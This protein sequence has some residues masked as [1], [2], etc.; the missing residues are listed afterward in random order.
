MEIQT[1]SASDLRD[2]EI[3][4][5]IAAKMKEFHDLNMPGPKTVLLWDRLRYMLL[6]IFSF[7]CFISY[8]YVH[9]K[10]RSQL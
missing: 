4:A 5:L 6:L 2:P 1:L 3:S 7:F 10:Q 8:R 9:L